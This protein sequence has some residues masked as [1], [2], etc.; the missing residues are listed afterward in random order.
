M[1][2]KQIGTELYWIVEISSGIRVGTYKFYTVQA[3]YNMLGILGNPNYRI[4]KIY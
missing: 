2:D 4:K 1:K 3:A